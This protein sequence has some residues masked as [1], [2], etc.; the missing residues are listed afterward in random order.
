[1][2]RGLC[3]ASLAIVRP[4][5]KQMPAKLPRQVVLV[6]ALLGSLSACAGRQ[7]ARVDYDPAES[8][9]RKMFWFNDKADVYVLEPVAKGWDFVVPDR[10]QTSIANFFKNLAFPVVFINS[11]LQAKPRAAAIE[12]ARFMA[13]TTFGLAGFFD[14][15]TPWGLE[16][17]EEDTGQ[18]LGYWGV[19][20]GPYLVWPFFGP[21]NVRDTFGLAGDSLL[22][23]YTFFII[24]YVTIG[25]NTVRI[26][27]DR[28]L[29]LDE[30]RNAKKA[31]I[32]YYVFVRN[33]Y[34]QRRN[35]LIEDGV[36]KPEGEEDL[37]EIEDE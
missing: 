36:V 30:V 29:F 21:S 2:S 27:N 3:P 9:N 8:F 34:L 22:G 18:T 4:A 1:V 5:K 14:P 16:R 11:T 19:P 23:L 31:S 10:V 17:Q 28:S 12:L 35:T 33:A 15:A 6:V 7:P 32:D 24:P 20:A 13:N 26:V 25:T 37:Y